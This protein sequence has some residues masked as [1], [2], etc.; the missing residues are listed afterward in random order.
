MVFISNCFIGSL[1]FAVDLLMEV[2]LI[3][4]SKCSYAVFVLLILLIPKS[5]YAVYVLLI[6]LITFIVH[7]MLLQYGIGTLKIAAFLLYC[8]IR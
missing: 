2:H 4:I 8:H 6:I 1:E 7:D 3:E 5:S